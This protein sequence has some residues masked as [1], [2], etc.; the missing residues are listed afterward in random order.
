[1]GRQCT[2][3]RE[4]RFIRGKLFIGYVRIKTMVFLFILESIKI[5]KIWIF[6]KYCDIL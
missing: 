3:D 6:A 5:E 2:E 1:V 4:E